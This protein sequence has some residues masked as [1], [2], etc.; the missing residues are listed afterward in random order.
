MEK[1]ILQLD[2]E[3]TITVVAD[4]LLWLFVPPKFPESAREPMLII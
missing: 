1:D 2:S 4:F 3:A